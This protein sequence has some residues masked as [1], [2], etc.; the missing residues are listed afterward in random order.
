MNESKVQIVKDFIFDEIEL[1][2][3][4]FFFFFNLIGFQS[5]EMIELEIRALDDT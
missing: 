4:G 3:M 5:R 2:K 1:K